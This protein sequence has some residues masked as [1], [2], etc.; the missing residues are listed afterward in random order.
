MVNLHKKQKTSCLVSQKYFIPSI[1]S[2][3]LVA[4]TFNSAFA[5]M[6]IHIH[7][8]GKK[9]GSGSGIYLREYKRYVLIIRI[10]QLQTWRTL[11][12]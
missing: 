2:T 4:T 11:C 12:L 1:I 7:N 10:R 9:H 6:K 3:T 5:S 8:Y